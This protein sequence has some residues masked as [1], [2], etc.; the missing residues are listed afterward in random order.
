M[1]FKRLSDDKVQIIV[2]SEDLEKRDVKKWDLMPSSPK[3]QEL[4]QEML[5]QAYEECG[6]EVDSDTQLMV[7]AYPMTTDSLVITLTKVKQSEKDI[8]D[9]DYDEDLEDAYNE[10]DDEEL[11][12]LASDELVYMFK[13][14][15]DVVQL[16]KLINGDYLGRSNMYKMGNVFYL[17]FIDPDNLTDHSLGMLGEYSNLVHLSEAYLMEHGKI[18]IQKDAVTKMA[19]L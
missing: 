14:F 8:L 12:E 19:G 7:E 15:E 17:T 4:F 11:A 6:F 13:S 10:L 3:A 5:D 9:T 2:S 1:K 18:M 16:C